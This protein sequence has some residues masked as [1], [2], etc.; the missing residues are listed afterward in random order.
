MWAS[1]AWLQMHISDLTNNM[2]GKTRLLN[3]L[4]AFDKIYHERVLQKLH[5]YGIVERKLPQLQQSQANT[6]PWSSTIWWDGVWFGSPTG[7]SPWTMPLSPLYMY[8]YAWHWHD[9]GMP[10]IVSSTVQ[11]L[12]II[13]CY[14]CIPNYQVTAR[15][16]Q[17]LKWCSSTVHVR[18][19]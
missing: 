18:V 11:P 14:I 7:I 10:N 19:L 8:M 13:L 1:A 2:V 15:H 6:H 16:C 9:I 5:H 3:M 4:K 12:L 17:L